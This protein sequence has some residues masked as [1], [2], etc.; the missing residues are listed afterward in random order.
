LVPFPKKHQFFQLY[1]TNSKIMAS[2]PDP[3][4]DGGDYEDCSGLGCEANVVDYQIG[5]MGFLC[6]QGKIVGRT[7]KQ[8][9]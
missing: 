9:Y 7:W 2:K 5:A 6:L 4:S 1:N 8:L 3:S